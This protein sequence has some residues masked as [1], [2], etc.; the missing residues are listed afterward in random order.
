MTA[1][2]FRAKCPCC[3]E[4]LTLDTKLRLLES[5]KAKRKSEGLD[6]GRLEQDQS[7][8]EDSF[9]KALEDEKRKDK[10]TLEDFL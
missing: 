9:S 7:R 10:P 5:P 2:N 4:W 8:A 3:G 1:R 6:V